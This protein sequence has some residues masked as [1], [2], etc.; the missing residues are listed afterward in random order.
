MGKSSD[1]GRLTALGCYRKWKDF[2]IPNTC[3][4][5]TVTAGRA[6]QETSCW[7]DNTGADEVRVYKLR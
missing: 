6:H 7:R 1:L 2:G 4:R 5:E 3:G